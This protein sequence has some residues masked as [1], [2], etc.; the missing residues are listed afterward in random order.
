MA[1]EKTPLGV[2]LDQQDRSGAEQAIS[3]MSRSDKL[4]ALIEHAYNEIDDYG[5]DELREILRDMMLDG[6]V[7]WA[8]K[9]D[10]QLNL[11]LLDVWVE[12][13]HEGS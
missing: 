5:R 7:G 11:E 10:D 8:Q 1:D 2:L 13:E 6:H 4:D 3:T 9:S 12:D